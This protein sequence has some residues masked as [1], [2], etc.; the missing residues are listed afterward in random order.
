MLAEQDLKTVLKQLDPRDDAK[1][2]AQLVDQILRVRVRLAAVRRKV[3]VMSG[4]GGVGK[5][6]VTASL[7]LALSRRGERVGVLDA[8][9]NGPS[10][11]R[12]LGL[13]GQTM[14]IDGESAE[15][16]AGPL[17]IKVAAMSFLSDPERPLGFKGPMD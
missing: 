5:S 3:L 8:D 9:L 14:A 2:Q 16:V 11:P 7:A 17:G 1:V 12:M 6:T 13:T 4:K 15:P 10:I